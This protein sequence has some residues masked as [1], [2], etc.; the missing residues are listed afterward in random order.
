MPL[1]VFC[2][3]ALV[4]AGIIWSLERNRLRAERTRAFGTAAIF[5]D[6]LQWT[7][8]QALSVTFALGALVRHERGLVPD[9]EALAREL[10]LFYPGVESLQLAPG[11]V[12]RRIYPLRGNEKALGHDLFRDP[13]R[14]KEAVLARDTGRLTLAG[15]FPLRQGG[16]GLIGRMPIYLPSCRG[17]P[18]F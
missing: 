3:V 15:P 9:F 4:A 13:A 11:G 7:L 5:A 8:G 2:L 16:T 10:L 1:A 12:V 17:E 6:S 14:A 18:R